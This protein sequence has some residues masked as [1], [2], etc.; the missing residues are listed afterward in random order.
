MA[1]LYFDHNATTPLAPEVREEMLAVLDHAVGNPSSSHRFGEENRRTLARARERV[2][3]LVGA[4]P[5]EIYFTS[6]GTEANNLVLLG[7]AGRSSAEAGRL[8]TT[9][10]EHPSVLNPCRQLAQRGRPV[11]F[12]PANSDGVVVANEKYKDVPGAVLRVGNLPNTGPRAATQGIHSGDDVILTAMGPGSHKVRGQ[13]E[14]T[15]LFRVIAEA[16]ALGAKGN[17]ST[18]ENNRR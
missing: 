4:Q 7:A 5:E 18:G 2:A 3:R 9:A 15:E 16:L 12:V 14:N 10:I 13:M 6:G 17:S 11:V 8:V 1:P